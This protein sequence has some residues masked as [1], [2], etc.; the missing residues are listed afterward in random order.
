MSILTTEK[1]RALIS[2]LLETLKASAEVEKFKTKKMLVFCSSV[3]TAHRLT[4]LLQY[5]FLAV[6]FA[7]QG[8]CDSDTD[9]LKDAVRVQE[10]SSLLQQRDRDAMLASFKTKSKEQAQAESNLRLNILVCS[11]AAARG[12]DLPKVDAVVNFDVPGNVKT[13]VHRVGR[14]A[15][16]GKSGEAF[17]ILLESEIYKLRRVVDRLRCAGVDGENGGSGKMRHKVMQRKVNEAGYFGLYNMDAAEYIDDKS[18]AA[19]VSERSGT[20]AQTDVLVN[21]SRRESVEWRK[22]VYSVSKGKIGKVMALEEAGR[23]KMTRSL[24]KAVVSR[25]SKNADLENQLG[26]NRL[27]DLFK[28]GAEF[29]KRYRDFMEEVAKAN[30]EGEAEKLGAEEDENGEGD[31]DKM[32]VEHVE[33]AEDDKMEV[34]EQSAKPQEVKAKQEATKKSTKGWTEAHYKRVLALYQD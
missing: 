22:I 8:H 12:I 1:P 13:Y 6:D 20:S 29:N 19:L 18:S 16:A 10:F 3:D 5:F 17:T 30:A 14:T 21:M 24:E 28:S 27:P 31:E 32:D 9:T 34:V 15:R 23:I 2:L 33:I 26:F 11:D 7:V 25:K 4:R